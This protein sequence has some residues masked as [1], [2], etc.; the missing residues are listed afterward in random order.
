M[1]P[2]RPLA[3]G[4][5]ICLVVALGGCAG[6]ELAQLQS[7]VDDLHARLYQLQRSSERQTTTT[8][9]SIQK[10]SQD[11]GEAFDE[12][13][14]AQSGLEEKINQ[15][16]NRL[17]DAEQ[18]LE[19]LESAQLQLQT[20]LEQG[21]LSLRQDLATRERD[22]RASLDKT[23]RELADLRKKL[24]ALEERQQQET[25]SIREALRL[26]NDNLGR[27]IDNLDTDV[28]NVYRSILK[29]L[30]VATPVAAESYPGD[31][32]VVAPGDT[33]SGIAQSLGVSVSSLQEL[34]EIT[35]PD[36]LYAGQRLRIPKQ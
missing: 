1:V 2:D 4:V 7:D 25:S 10:V 3:H 13:R 35:D 29:E 8:T 21:N 36:K 16:S 9:A 24:T 26:S 14:F 30:G 32:Y 27:R 6:K 17:L 34:N 23:A 28:Q 20:Q 11:I 18:R 12:I 31:V 33:L 22:Y 15:I 5:A 19:G